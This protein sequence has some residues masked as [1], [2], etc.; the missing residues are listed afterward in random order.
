M[1]LVPFP[2]NNNSGMERKDRSKLISA[3]SNVSIQYNFSVI[4]LALAL[5]D[6]HDNDAGSVPPAYPRTEDQTSTLKSVVFVGAIVGQMVMGYAGDVLG[7]RPAMLMTNFLTFV[8]ALGSALFTWGSPA[9]IYT[10]MAVCRFILGVGVGGKYP[11]AATMRSETTEDADKDTSTEVAKGFFWQTPGSMAPYLVGLLLLSIFGREHHG[12]AYMAS[13][14]LQFRLLLGIGALPAFVVMILTYYQEDN[15]QLEIAQRKAVAE[16]LNEG[17]SPGGSCPRSNPFAIARRHPRFWLIFIGTGFS[18]FLYDV[19]YYGVSL[20][21][22][23]ITDAVFGKSETLFKTCW[24]NT[25]INAMGLPA[26][27]HAIWVLKSIGSKR[28]QVY[29]FISVAV[30]CVGLATL[31]W[32]DGDGGPGIKGAAMKN[33]WVVFGGVCIL[34]FAL[35]WGVNVSTYVLPTEAFPAEV[36]STFF[37]LSAATGKLG[38][39]LGG[40]AFDPFIDRFGFAWLYIVCACIALLGVVVTHFFIEPM[41]KGSCFQIEKASD[42]DRSLYQN[43]DSSSAKIDKEL[44]I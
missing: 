43:V 17:G 15:Q 3:I 36:R 11:L 7:R 18:W 23:D 42:Q 30:V 22:P 19:L 12:A 37:G 35:N 40:F 14:S 1:L 28:L 21:Q 10:I 24:Q 31:L 8:G 25:I 39:V 32:V 33:H 27:M 9:T 4:A 38:A 6:N 34:I 26:V 20:V 5:M 13:T 29:G 44:H 2:L 41:G 16:S